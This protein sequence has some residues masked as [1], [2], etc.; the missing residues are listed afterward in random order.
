MTMDRSL[1]NRGGLKGSRSVLTRAERITKMMDEN[2]FDAEADSPFGLPKLRV[3][4]SKAGSK[5]K[6][7]EAPAAE[8]AAEGAEAAAPAKDEKAKS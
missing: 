5:G 2:R 1:K 6:K 7:E 3:R 8:A 4:T